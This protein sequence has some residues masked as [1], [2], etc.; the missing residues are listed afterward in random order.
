MLQELARTDLELRWQRRDEIT[1]EYYL[2]RF[3][4]LDD[5]SFVP[6]LLQ[7]E[8]TVRQKAGDQVDLTEYSERFPKHFDAFKKLLSTSPA[9]RARTYDAKPAV[10]E[11]SEAAPP[12]K[13]PA[14]EVKEVRETKEVKQT[15][16]VKESKDWGSPAVPIKT[17]CECPRR[18]GP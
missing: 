12:A 11:A 10:Q 2:T 1:A 13:E 17:K 14:K 6:T 5:P 4:E 16:E 15:K 7:D 8:F 3:P 18:F 9:E